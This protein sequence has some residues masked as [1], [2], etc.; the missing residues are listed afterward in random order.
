MSSLK[1]P[2]L[3]LICL[4]S[5]GCEHVEPTNISPINN[6]G[7]LLFGDLTVGDENLPFAHLSSHAGYT[8]LR[9]GESVCAQL[10]DL[11]SGEEF[12]V[13]SIVPPWPSDDPYLTLLIEVDGNLNL[14]TNW[15]TDTLDLETIHMRQYSGFFKCIPII[16]R[17]DGNREDVIV[18]IK[19]DSYSYALRSTDTEFGKNQLHYGFLLAGEDFSSSKLLVSYNKSSILETTVLTIPSDKIPLKQSSLAVY[20]LINE[21]TSTGKLY[22]IDCPLNIPRQIATD[23]QLNPGLVPEECIQ[24]DSIRIQKEFR[25]LDFRLPDLQE[26]Q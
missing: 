15:K 7:R 3:L 13:T 6:S 12:I 18:R 23:L 4:L 11:W 16:V 10:T 8:K 21:D 9:G 22:L 25:R 2:L 5:A 20:V 24:M 19:Q 26:L 14:H 17:N 1:T